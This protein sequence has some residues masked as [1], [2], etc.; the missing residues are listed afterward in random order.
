MEDWMKFSFAAA[1]VCLICP[2]LLGII[3]GVALFCGMWYLAYK[4][5]GG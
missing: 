4:L 1:I 2:P 3:A 5:I